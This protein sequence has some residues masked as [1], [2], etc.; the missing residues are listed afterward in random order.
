LVLQ[1]Q[2]ANADGVELCLRQLLQ[3]ELPFP[4]LNLSHQPHLLTI[5][6]QPL[7]LQRYNQLLVGG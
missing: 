3:P 4:S 7:V 1:Q 2:S 6:Q 5:G